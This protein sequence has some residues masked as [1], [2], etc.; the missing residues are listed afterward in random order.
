MSAISQNIKRLATKYN[1]K[2]EFDFASL[3]ENI[4]EIFPKLVL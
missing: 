4:L 2:T 1:I 3:I